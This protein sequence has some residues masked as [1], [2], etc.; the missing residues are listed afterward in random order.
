MHK[1][2]EGE[3]VSL[4]H[5]ILQMKNRDNVYALHERAAK[6]Y[7]QLSVLKF[8]EDYIGTTPDLK[9]SREE[10]LAKVIDASERSESDISE[11]VKGVTTQIEEVVQPV[12]KEEMEIEMVVESK[13]EIIVEAPMEDAS[14]VVDE[15]PE[16]KGEISEETVEKIFGTPDVMAKNDPK[17]VGQVQ[18]TLDEEIKE[19]ISADLATSM[20]ETA[21][22]ETPVFV[23]PETTKKRSINEAVQSQNLQ[24][25]LNDRIAFVKHLFDDSQED[26]NRVVS[27]LNSFTTEQEAKEFV[28][29]FVKPDY[30]WEGKE[31]Y[32]ERLVVLIERKFA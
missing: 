31:E 32:E 13:E 1:K 4:A 15:T 17:D 16:V 8:V 21:T 14:E 6:I 5:S 22:K 30:N 25:G 24:I 11:G 27:Q 10:I 9:E 7:E 29:N 28:E 20:F 26:F 18:L 3:L 12:E 19:A 2:L 23:K